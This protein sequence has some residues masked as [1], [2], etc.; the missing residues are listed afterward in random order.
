VAVLY[1]QAL[2]D[3]AT[4]WLA[5]PL[6]NSPEGKRSAEGLLELAT[7]W[8]AINQTGLPECL[9]QCQY[10]ERAQAVRN[11]L[12][13]FSR[14]LLFPDAM[15]D[16]P[17]SK[18]QIAPAFAGQSF[19]DEG[20]AAPVTAENLTDDAAEYF[21]KKGR[22]DAF[23]LRSQAKEEPASEPGKTE[24]EG[25]TRDY[26][27]ELKTEQD[28]HTA[29]TGKLQKEQEAHT[30]ASDALKSEKEAHKTT[31]KD[32]S[33]VQKQLAAAQ[34]QLAALADKAKD[35]AGDAASEADATK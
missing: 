19:V 18:Y 24:P 32:L 27:A 6:T 8:A 1:T 15:S 23:I 10:S 16:T 33:E 26:A 20:L 11:Y 17:Q 2:A 30:K 28:A 3:R 14:Q 12:T 34:K 35:A 4:A 5:R 7:I 13:E 29:T 25:D 22:S 21:I 9:R 31:K